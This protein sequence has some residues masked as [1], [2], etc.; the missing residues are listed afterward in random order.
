MR[1]KASAIWL[2]F[3]FSTQTNTTRFMDALR[4]RPD[5]LAEKIGQYGPT[6]EAACGEE[7][8]RY[9]RVQVRPAHVAN[10]VN[11][12]QDDQAER[13]GHSDVSNDASSNVV[14]DNGP[15]PDEYQGERAKRFCGKLPHDGRPVN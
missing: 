11:H 2:R 10:G 12:R 4:K 5:A 14:D 13:E 1:A 3:E 9:G 8:Q 7:A 6:G 15:G